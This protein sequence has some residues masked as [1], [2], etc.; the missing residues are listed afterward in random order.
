MNNELYADYK[1]RTDPAAVTCLYVSGRVKLFSV[2]YRSPS[3][4]LS[5][6]QLHWRQIGGHV[7][8]VYNSGVDV[9]WGI[10]CDNTAWAYNGGWGGMFLK[11]LEGSGKIN[12]MIDTHTYYVYEN[13][14]WN[15]ISGFTAKSLPTDRHMWSD[16]TGRQKRSK[17]HT[18]L[19]ST[20]CEWISDWAIDYNIPG[21]AD[22]EGWQYAIDFPATYHAQK[23]LTD[24]VRRRR[25]MKKCRLTSSGPWQELS[26]SKILDASLQ[27]LDSDVDSALNVEDI[28]V[29]AWAIASNGDVLI[30]HG[31]ST[32]N[33]RGDTWEHIVSD[34]P[35]V[36]ISV[37]P[38]GQVWAVARNGMIFFRYG[39]TK[40]NPCGDAWQQ[41][42]AP[43]GVTF[44]VISVGRAGIWALD[45]Q[46]R[47]AVRK[48]V[49]RTFPEGSHWQFLPNSAN[50]PPHTE[51]HCGFR[52]VS[53]GKEVWAIS[54]NGVICRRCGITNENPAGAGWSLGIAVHMKILNIFKAFLNLLY[55]L[56]GQWQHL[57]LEG[58]M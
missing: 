34:Q 42:E 20:H 49:T 27:V 53:V 13:Q 57:S 17:E 31:V 21:G 46:Q 41:V 33:P 1:Y 36:G 35:L 16:A 7:K 14:R 25:W 11:G 18:K 52:S 8:R 56:Q 38:T 5:M 55:L 43:S 32:L 44:K 39:I 29:A 47:L 37:G 40:L 48:E 19:L 10:S 24:C 58:Y 45:N 30:R 9:V 28:P 22:K 2:I 4:I 54:L 12:A 15:P 26:H 6:Q 51:T 3:V 50:V 23:K